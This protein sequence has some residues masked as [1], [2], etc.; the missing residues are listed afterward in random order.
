VAGSGIS[1]PPLGGSGYWGS[2]GAIFP[3]ATLD[4]TKKDYFE[5]AIDTT[6]YASVSLVLDAGFNSGNGP[7][8]VA[9]YYGTTSLPAAENGTLLYSNANAIAKQNVFST[10]TVPTAPLITG[11]GLNPNGNT[12]FRVYSYNSKTESAGSDFYL[13]NVTFTGCKTPLPPRITKS[14]S[15][16]VVAKDGTSTLTFTITNPNTPALA[17]FQL[18]GIAFTDVMPAG[19]IV[20]TPTSTTCG[21]GTVTIS[22]GG[23][24]LNFSGGSLAANSTGTASCTV[25]ALT[26]VT[27]TGPHDNVSGF[28]TSTTTGSNNAGAAG[29]ATASIVA[30]APPAITK[31][32]GT[33]T[34]F[35]GGTT[36]LTFSISNP[37]TSTPISGVGFSDT[38]PT[39]PG[40]MTVASTPGATT[41]GCG[42]PTLTAAANTGSISM[43]GGTIAANSVCVVTV[44]VTIPATPTTGTYTNSIFSVSH[45]V[46]G[47]G[48]VPGTTGLPASLTAK[49]PSP[50]L[51]FIK[52]V[53]ATNA[54][55]WV[56]NLAVAAGANVFYR[57]TVENTGDVPLN[58]VTINDPKFTAAQLAPC[59]VTLPIAVAA[60]N[61]HIATCV[62]GPVVAAAVVT[63]NTATASGTPSTGGTAITSPSD[64]ATYQPFS[65]SMVKDAVQKYFTNAGQVVNY[66][67]KI[68]NLGPATL[69]TPPNP[70][71]SVTDNKATVTCPAYSTA[72]GGTVDNL[73]TQ[74]ESIICTASYTITAGD[75]TAASVTNLATATVAGAGSGQQSKNVPKANA[76]F[77]HLPTSGSPAYASN[78][79]NA[80][81]ASHLT[82][83]SFLGAVVPNELDGTNGAFTRDAVNDDGVFPTP[84]TPWKEGDPAGANGGSLRATVVCATGTCFLGAWIDWNGD[85]NFTGPNEQVTLM[86]LSVLNGVNTFTFPIPV[87]TSAGT[88]VNGSYFM[89]FRLYSANPG[90]T[91]SPTGQATNSSGSAATVGEV[92]DQFFT[93]TNGVVTP[94]TVSYFNARRQGNGTAIDWSTSTESAN[95]G[96]NLYVRKAGKLVKV[97]EQIIPSKAIDSL[98]RLDYSYFA[99]TEGSEWVIEEVSVQRSVRKHGP[100][101]AEAVIGSREVTD[102]I[103]WKAVKEQ[104]QGSVVVH[105]SNAK[106]GPA[107]SIGLRVRETGIYRLT[108]EGL[109]ASGLDLNGV[110]KAQI[111][112]T[113]Q[114]QPVPLYVQANGQFGPGCYIEFQGA[115]IDTIYTD[116]NYY[117]LEINGSRS[118]HMPVNNALPGMGLPTPAFYNDVTLVH[119]QRAYGNYAPGADAW[120]DT[121]M[122]TY[123]SAR[124]WTFPFD[125]SAL[126]TGSSSDASLELVVWGVTNFV[127]SPDHHLQ[128]SVNGVRVSDERFDGLVEKVLKVS[129]P[130]GTLHEGSNTLELT[131]P[132]DTGNP[133]DLVNLDKF[134]VIYPRAFRARNGRLT[135]TSDGKAFTVTDLP[136]SDVSIYRADG[137]DKIRLRGDVAP[138]AANTYSVTFAGTGK[139][140]TYFVSTSASVLVPEMV[141][142]R[143][144]V[145]LNTKADLL[146]ISHPN[147][148]AGLTPLIDQRR[149]QGL[150]VNVVDVNDVYAQ[151]TYGVFDPSAIKKYIAYAVRNLG[152]KAVLLVGGDTYDYRNYLG[153]NSVSFIPSIYVSTGSIAKFVPADPSYADVNDDNVPDVAIGR[154][155]VRSASDLDLMVRKTLAYDAKDYGRTSAFVSDLFDGTESFSTISNA[156][157]AKLPAGWTAEHIDLDRTDWATARAA[158]INAMN[159]GTSLVTY[160]GH[161]GTTFWGTNGLF[162]RTDGPALT[163]AGRPFIAVQWGCWN[164]YYVEPVNNTMVQS[165]LFSGD[166]GAAAMLGSSTL[167]NSESEELLGKSLT[168]RMV[169]P[170]ASIGQ[171]LQDAKTEVAKTHPELSDVMLGW[172]L[173]GDPTLVVD[174]RR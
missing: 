89:R 96:F 170:G 18:D 133:Y 108:Y 153:V 10:I 155:P 19:V 85:G 82:G 114:G 88:L 59:T 7:T 81:G 142:A 47:A 110:P 163:N 159:R 74:G 9:V 172:T 27:T 65:I 131:L 73:F 20:S 121:E 167:V 38:L 104:L 157:A 48:T 54:G 21:T 72:T 16:P 15:P 86:P 117:T 146:V 77:G 56:P 119:R 113:N 13:D 169:I 173:M 94:V 112:I 46:S 66:T 140:A 122:L 90:A 8:G 103:D 62:V 135:F 162:R 123:T 102:K 106:G 116:T 37:N 3:G 5:F 75:V 158:V 30:I 6:N 2:N 84:A 127:R 17:A 53:G 143:E 40:A 105:G 11:A 67:Y 79:F 97:N 25:T 120:Y 63:P 4:T 130:S 44:N 161:S 64:T 160:V 168:P 24:Q 107:T 58:S 93:V 101:A 126:A 149:S 144:Q 61:N 28:V 80:S 60:N 136:S 151:Y 137:A 100:Y 132:G 14:F 91:M 92:E 45:V 164:T 35:A 50:S 125:V 51:A 95:V 33:S 174:P 49:A 42:T 118:V 76:N 154:F 12:Y 165:L 78:L 34:L 29:I 41:S 166:K 98:E 138:G 69:S 70:A 31:A 156:L 57:F 99:N 43:T 83:S 36:T 55:P 141:A 115:A 171:A 134:S 147:F 152:T 26:T 87:T 71:P 129:I 109:K 111:A 68:T 150:T 52:E 39:A 22:G 1:S 148:I 128:V 139:L 32:F 23:T 124:S 145:D